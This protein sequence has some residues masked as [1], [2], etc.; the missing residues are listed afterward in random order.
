MGEASLL[1]HT[2]THFLVVQGA[3]MDKTQPAG[4]NE[5]I[6]I[7]QTCTPA[8]SLSPALQLDAKLVTAAT[9]SKN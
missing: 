8:D 5:E 7:K 4:L 6:H 3:S 2:L 1:H 9:F